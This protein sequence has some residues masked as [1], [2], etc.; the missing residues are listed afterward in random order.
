M[1]ELLSWFTSNLTQRF[2]PSMLD[3]LEKDN[4]FPILFGNYLKSD[5][6]VV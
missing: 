6:F 3:I 1:L 4:F 5:D 2:D